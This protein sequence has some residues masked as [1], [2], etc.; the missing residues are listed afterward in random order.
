VPK[1][2]QETDHWRLEERRGEVRHTLILRVGVLEQGGKSSLCIVKNISSMGVQFKFY[3]PPIVGAT[4]SIRVADETAVEG[5]VVWAKDDVAGM[6]FFEELDS[7]TLL[8]VRQK[9]KSIRRRNMPRIDVDA[10]ATLRSGGRVCRARVCDISS[11][12]ARVRTTAPLR[13]GDRAVLAFAD[14]PSLN[15][16]VRWSDGGESGLVF[17]APIPM[18]IIAHWIDGRVRLSA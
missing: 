14:L 5:H 12:G 11:L 2:K 10:S 15:A 8:R 4:A 16:F 13:A 3:A 6:N 18:Q 17:E 9:L 7:R 1:P